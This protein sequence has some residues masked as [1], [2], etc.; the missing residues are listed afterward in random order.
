VL[1]AAFSADGKL[2][3]TGSGDRSVRIWD[4]ATGKLIVE[5]QGHEGDVSSVVFSPDGRLVASGSSDGTARIWDVLDGAVLRTLEVHTDSVLSGAFSPDSRF[6]VTG[7]ADRT[8]RVWDTKTGTLMLTLEG[9]EGGVWST[10]FSDDGTSISTASGNTIVR[11]WAMPDFLLGDVETQVRKSC[12]LLWI[13]N[14]PLAFRRS[15]VTTY[16]VLEGQ[17]IDPDYPDLFFSPCRDVLPSEAFIPATAPYA[18][19]GSSRSKGD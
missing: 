17:P 7:S 2:V 4:S 12:E 14:V 19:A 18:W 16:P 8:A 3:A 5:L 1:S 11:R 13:A 9:N 15:D 6:L 10:V